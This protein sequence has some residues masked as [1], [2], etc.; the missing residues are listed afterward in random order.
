MFRG[1]EEALTES[2]ATLTAVLDGHGSISDSGTQGRR[3]Y[4]GQEYVFAW[5]GATTPLPPATWRIMA[6]LGSRLLFYA[7]PD[8]DVDDAALGDALHGG[9]YRRKS[10]D[11]R[12]AV[13]EVLETRWREGHGCEVSGGRLRS[14]NPSR[15]A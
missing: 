13:R 10:A 8:V 12:I 15:N 6:Q 1:R 14:R 3:G 7:M 2:F 11:C 4:V 5:V 9:T